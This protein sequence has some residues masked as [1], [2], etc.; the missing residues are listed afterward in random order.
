MNAKTINTSLAVGVI[1]GSASVS[2][3][4]AAMYNIPLALPPATNG[5][6]PSLALVYNSNSGDGPL[7]LGWNLTG[8]SAISRV[9]AD[10]YHDE[11]FRAV[12]NSPTDFFAL[13]GQRLVPT[14][15]LPY[16][17][18]D[19]EYDTEV[20]Q[21]LVVQVPQFEDNEPAY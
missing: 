12:S 4:G 10:H 15:G 5:F 13:D 20:A 1:A 19:T 21:Y 3:I 17:A 16:G 9:G 2:S 7:G 11:L 6:G 18:A 8:S 14:N